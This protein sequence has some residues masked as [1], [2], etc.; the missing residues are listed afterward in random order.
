MNA[1]IEQINIHKY[2]E[3]EKAHRDLGNEAVMDWIIKY[4]KIFREQYDKNRKNG[5]S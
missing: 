1:Q 5:K 4:A 2:L 3:S